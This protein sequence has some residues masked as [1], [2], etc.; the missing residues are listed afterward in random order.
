MKLALSRSK[1]KNKTMRK[2]QISGILMRTGNLRVIIQDGG[3]MQ[4]HFQIQDYYA[5]T[6][7]EIDHLLFI[8][9]TFPRDSSSL[10]V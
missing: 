2:R 1:L 6:T 3:V 7:S 4:E 8:L 9:F 5:V 10:G